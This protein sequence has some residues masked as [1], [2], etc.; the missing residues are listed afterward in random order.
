[1]KRTLGALTLFVLALLSGP[2]AFASEFDSS[3]Q[4]GL[5]TRAFWPDDLAR[6]E[7]LGV[8]LTSR[9]ELT[10]K[11]RP[12]RQQLRLVGRVGALDNDRSVLIVEEGFVGYKSGWLNLRVGP[13][14]LNWTA[15]EA[16]HPADVMNSRN[17]DSNVE[18]ADKIGEPMVSASIRM[19]QGRLELFYMPFR[20]DPRLP[21]PA[22]R[23]SF[24]PAGTTLGDPLWAGR[25]GAIDDDLIEHQFAAR[26]SQTI[27][28][29]DIALQFVQHLDRS[30]P[31]IAIDPANGVARPVYH[32]VSHVGLT[33]TQVI[34]SVVLKVEAAHRIFFEP[35]T[36]DPGTLLLPGGL[37]P[38]DHTVVALGFEVGWAFDSGED[39]TLLAEAQGVFGPSGEQRRA[40]ASPFQADGLVGMRYTLNDI[41]NKAFFAGVIFDVERLEIIG[42]ASYSQRLSDTWTVAAS[43]R[44][45]HAPPDDTLLP[46]TLQAL[47][48]SHY[49]QLLLTRH[50]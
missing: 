41:D 19:W 1:M 22:S 8:S 48:Q 23:L 7:D 16:F 35:D 12:W 21:G 34:E 31:T 17:F 20:M 5:E 30:Q 46:G 44:I 32:M 50:F 42:N 9:L 18:N 26:I 27:D 13:Q 25:D 40:A 36:P 29:A 49:L 47:D 45:L 28:D 6:T 43:L 11:H 37:A 10:H 15:T 3:G 4:I 14:I 24:A 38:E 33:Y 2:N 39:L